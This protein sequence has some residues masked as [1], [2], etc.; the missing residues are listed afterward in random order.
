MTDAFTATAIDPGTKRTSTVHLYILTADTVL[1]REHE[2]RDNTEH[3]IADGTMLYG[4]EVTGRNGP[5]LVCDSI[6][7]WSKPF[8]TPADALWSLDA[9]I[10][11]GAWK[12]VTA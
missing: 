2:D 5:T 9:S 12:R 11:G 6:A 7:A 8:T 4:V 3:A 10:T 1:W